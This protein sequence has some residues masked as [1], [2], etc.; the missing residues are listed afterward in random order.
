MKMFSKLGN[1]AGRWA[2]IG[3]II[4]GSHR[5]SVALAQS[6]A[7][8]PKPA[9]PKPAEAVQPPPKAQPKLARDRARG[10]AHELAAAGSYSQR[11]ALWE[12]ELAG[13]DPAVIPVQL[14]AGNE[15]QII[16]GFD[17]LDG[18]LGLAV[19]DARGRVIA[20]E[21]HR[22]KGKMVMKIKPEASGVHRIR[23]R[24]LD[25]EAPPVAAALTYIY[26]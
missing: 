3:L 23:I 6:P 19:F 4:A 24:A 16:V 26:K 7:V 2:M 20:S 10:L 12:A 22:G 14:Y 13:A 9:A 17:V 8:E 21:V 1:V 5:G 18:R 11:A 25:S 15:Y